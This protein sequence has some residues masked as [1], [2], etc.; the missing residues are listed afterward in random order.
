MQYYIT[1]RNTSH[2]YKTTILL[3]YFTGRN[4][5]KEKEDK[6]N[7]LYAWPN[8]KQ[9]SISCEDLYSCGL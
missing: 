9:P 3:H 4:S 8:T 2:Y 5:W 6:V 1:L 7:S